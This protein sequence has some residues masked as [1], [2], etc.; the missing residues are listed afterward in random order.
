[1]DSMRGRINT[2]LC[3]LTSLPVLGS[4]HDGHS[5]KLSDGHK[6]GKAGGWSYLET[7]KHTI[8]LG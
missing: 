8:R 4:S 1:M 7:L 6:T 3:D 2:F 5:D